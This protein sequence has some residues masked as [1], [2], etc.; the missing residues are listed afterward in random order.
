M[1]KNYFLIFFLLVFTFSGYSQVIENVDY[2]LVGNSINIFYDINDYTIGEKYEIE[3]RFVNNEGQVVIPRTLWGDFGIVTG[4]KG[5]K[6]VWSVFQDTQGLTGNY[7]AV[8]KIS[9][10][11]YKRHTV[12]AYM[13]LP[14]VSLIGLK[15]AYVDKFGGY[16]GASIRYDD[17]D[18]L[19]VVGPVIRAYKAIYTYAGF[20][21]NVF[22]P[23]EII[24]EAGTIITPRKLGFVAFDL[25]IGLFSYTEYNTSAIP[26]LSPDE[27]IKDVFIK[28]GV[29]ISIN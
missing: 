29:G 10:K 9:K 6:I 26:S 17:D 16:I 18:P 24:I 13:N 28:V 25:G 2:N 1:M 27:S 11:I 21:I 8:V 14:D 12:F 19:V 5:K 15:Y 23:E 4:G 20:G 7:Q 3:V 22:T